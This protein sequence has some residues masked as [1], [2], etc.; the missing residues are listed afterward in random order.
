MP[1]LIWT[2][3]ALADVARLYSFLLPKSSDAA[4]RAVKAIRQGVKILAQH[5]E[6]GRPIEDLLPEFR[7]WVI[8]FGQGAYVALYRY[9]GKQIVILAVRHGREAGY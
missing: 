2:P 3:P 5:P 1:Q 6:I 4:S 7:E 8:E 9:D